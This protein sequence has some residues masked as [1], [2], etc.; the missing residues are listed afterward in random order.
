MWKARL[1]MAFVALLGVGAAA[2]VTTKSSSPST[3]PTRHKH[4]HS[5]HTPFTKP[6]RPHGSDDE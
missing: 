4:L 6:L 3:R 1:S 2:V 5:T